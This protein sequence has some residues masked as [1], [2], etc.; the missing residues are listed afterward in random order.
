MYAIIDACGRQYKVEEGMVVYFEKL[1]AKEGEKVTF[2][3]VALVSNNDK[4][5]VGNPTIA[6]AKVEGRVISQGR[7]KKIVVFK[8]K[9]K[10]NERTTRGH[11]QDY[12]KV[13]ITSIKVSEAKKAT[14]KT[15]EVKAEKVETKKAEEK[16]TKTEA[17]PKTEKKAETKTA[18]ETK[19][20]AEKK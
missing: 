7:G 5:E 3:K 10:K 11:R 8:Y 9:P 2:D 16:T 4:I 18:K 14:A 19:P 6:G 13:E 17:K 1:D 15:E 20:K 12:T